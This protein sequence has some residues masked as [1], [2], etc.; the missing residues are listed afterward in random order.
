MAKS[1]VRRR[2][3]AFR[4]TLSY[5]V[6]R[7]GLPDA[8]QF[9]HWVGAALSGRRASGEVSIR[10]VDGDEGRALNRQ[11]RHRDYATN[12]LS[13]VADLPPGIGID[14]LGDVVLCAPVIES[15]A[16]TQGKALLDHYAHLTVHGTLHLIG[17][18]HETPAEARA[19]ESLEA[20]VL[21]KI[22][23]SD[24]YA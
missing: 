4:V 14:L 6:E 18:D 9:E 3:S 19:M 16:R 2:N 5:G 7:S 20:Q 10:V 15:E 22:G 23:I 11:Y 17:H 21:E 1:P 24:P 8:S 12:V 13:F